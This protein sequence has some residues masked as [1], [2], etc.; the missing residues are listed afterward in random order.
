M[1]FHVKH[2]A[3][4]EEKKWYLYPH[5]VPAKWRERLA[6]RVSLNSRPDTESVAYIIW[7]EATSENKDN[8]LTVHQLNKYAS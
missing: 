5:R 4:W 1:H 8:Q 2:E 7:H 3:N 6:M